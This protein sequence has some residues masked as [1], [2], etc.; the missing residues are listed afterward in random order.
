MGGDQ[1]TG[2]AELGGGEAASVRWHSSAFLYKAGSKGETQIL[3]VS[4]RP[5]WTTEPHAHDGPPGMLRATLEG[6][7][8]PSRLR[9]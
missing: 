8:R 4:E 9:Q 6:T 2:G 3:T 1:Q 5:W 7:M